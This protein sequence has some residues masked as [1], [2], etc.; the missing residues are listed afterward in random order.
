MDKLLHLVLLLLSLGQ[1]ED[2]SCHLVRKGCVFNPVRAMVVML[3]VVDATKIV[4]LWD[5]ILWTR[6]MIKIKFSFYYF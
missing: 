2:V 6:T 5:T 3:E 1:V 4:S